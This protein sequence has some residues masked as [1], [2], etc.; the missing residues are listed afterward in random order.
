MHAEFNICKRFTRQFTV[1]LPADC[2]RSIDSLLFHVR[3]KFPGIL[4]QNYERNTQFHSV[5][6]SL[7]LLFI[8]M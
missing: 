5:L 6:V 8:I 3:F 1:I 2:Q 7:D 4:F